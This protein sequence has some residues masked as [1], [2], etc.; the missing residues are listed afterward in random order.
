MDTADSRPVVVGVDESD[1]ARAAADWAADLA[2]AWGAPLLLVHTVPGLPQDAPIEPVPAWLR[3]L[4]DA[5]VRTGTD[6]A[7][8]EIL[9][10]G[11]VEQLVRRSED[12]R[13]LVLGSYGDGGWSGMLAGSNALGLLARAACPVAVVRGA[14][15]QVPPPRSGP[16]VVGV[17]GSVAGAAALELAADLAQSVGSRLVAVHTWN[18]VITGAEGGARRRHEPDEVL[19]AEGTALLEHA[20]QPVAARHPGLTLERHVDADTPLRDLLARAEGAR[21]LVVGQRRPA[22]AEGMLL[23]STSRGL[24]EFAPCPVVVVPPPATPPEDSDR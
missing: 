15:P 12:A 22:P 3:E 6:T 17:D 18:D 8:S 4:L 14:A 24:V 9:P 13:M 19:A 16:V 1:S 20:L 2:A 23:G 11:A 21:M 7:G 5:A 10:G